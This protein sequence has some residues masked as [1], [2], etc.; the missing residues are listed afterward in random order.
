MDQILP[1]AIV[2]LHRCEQDLTIC[3][4]ANRL[5]VQPNALEAIAFHS[6]ELSLKASDSTLSFANFQLDG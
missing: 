6:L 3:Q 4:N 1:A 5:A 2:V